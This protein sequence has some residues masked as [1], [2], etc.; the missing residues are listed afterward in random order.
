MDESLTRAPDPQAVDRMIRAGTIVHGDAAMMMLP[1]PDTGEW[2]PDEWPGP[3]SIGSS[4]SSTSVLADG[5]H[6]FVPDAAPA[7]W[8][9]ARV[10]HD[11]VRADP[12]DREPSPAR[13]PV[14][15]AWY[16]ATLAFMAP[17]P[18]LD[19]A[20][21]D[22]LTYSVKSRRRAERARALND[23]GAAWGGCS[24]FVRLNWAVCP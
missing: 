5:T 24:G 9:M 8:A 7:H 18:Y 20:H 3:P 12:S 16:R 10:L 4:R 19:P 6:G 11:Q 23:R 1:D 15:R 14:V 17:I 21:L 22:R 13:V 2:P